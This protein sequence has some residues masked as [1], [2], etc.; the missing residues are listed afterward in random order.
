MSKLSWT[1]DLMDSGDVATGAQF[2]FSASRYT[3]TLYKNKNASY[4]GKVFGIGAELLLPYANLITRE[5]VLKD[6]EAAIKTYLLE[7]LDEV[8]HAA[9]LTPIA[10]VD[11]IVQKVQVLSSDIQRLSAQIAEIKYPTQEEAKSD[12]ELAVVFNSKTE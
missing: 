8:S 4:T 6:A 12:P 7:L 1:E 10:R 9:V 2:I 3:V 11:Q 5:T